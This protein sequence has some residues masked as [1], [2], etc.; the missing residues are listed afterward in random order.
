M[1]AR[2]SSRKSRRWGFTLIELLVV[3]AI[4]ALLISILLPSLSKAREQART[5]LCASRI[6]QLCKAIMF[7]ADDYDGAPPFLGVGFENL[8]ELDGTF[9]GHP[10][11]WWAEQED[12]LIPHIPTI[13]NQPES[14]WEPLTVG[15]GRVS[16]VRNGD[17]F[18]YTRFENLYKCPDFERTANKEQNQFNF[19]RS[20][21]GRRVLSQFVGDDTTSQLAPGPIVKLS[22]VY[23]PAAMFMV[24]DEQWDFHVAGNYGGGPTE[25]IFAGDFSGYWMGADSIHGVVGDCIGDY[26]GVKKKVVELDMMRASKRGN[27]AHYD[28]HVELVQD[29][30]PGRVVNINLSELT[31][32]LGEA[33]KVLGIIL[34]QIYA[35]RGL[36]TTLTD[37]LQWLL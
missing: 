5:T 1:R 27:I 24:L 9:D 37:A 7:Y 2:A 30:M 36:N 4:I 31:S 12:W 15:T 14:Q 26:H 28:G 11:S 35:Q 22:A 17:L 3:V 34:Q 16:H 29:P 33:E 21:M 32:L 8:D 20:V 18:A 6:A 10:L 19:T 25:G 13:W 23:S